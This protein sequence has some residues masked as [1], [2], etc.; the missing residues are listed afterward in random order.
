[1]SLSGSRGVKVHVISDNQLYNF[2]ADFAYSPKDSSTNQLDGT[3][4]LNNS[5]IHILEKYLG[6]I[7]SNISGRATGDLHVSGKASDTKL[8]GK[9]RLDSTTMT[10][11]YTQC[12]YIFDNN[13]IITFNP[14]EIDFGIIKIRDTLN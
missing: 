2:L 4:T 7:F 3:I 10:V 14:D 1:E 12:R 5:G 11:N 13:T 8:T 6:D 9:V